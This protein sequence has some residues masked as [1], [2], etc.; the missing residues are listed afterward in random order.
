LV[1]VVDPGQEFTDAAVGMAV[2]DL[3]E[4]VGEVGLTMLN[5]ATPTASPGVALTETE[6]ELLDHLVRTFHLADA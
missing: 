3:G 5:R 1:D 6:I 4:D 2:D